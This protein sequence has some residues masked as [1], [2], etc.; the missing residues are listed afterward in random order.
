[1]A[2]SDGPVTKSLPSSVAAYTFFM[3]K[4][5]FD[6]TFR[7]PLLVSVSSLLVSD[8]STPCGLWNGPCFSLSSTSF[9]SVNRKSYIVHR[10]RK[11]LNPI[12]AEKTDCSLRETAVV[13]SPPHKWSDTGTPFDDQWHELQWQQ[14]RWRTDLKGKNVAKIWSQH[15]T[16]L[17]NFFLNTIITLIKRPLQ[18]FPAPTLIV[19][20]LRDIVLGPP[21]N[22]TRLLLATMWRPLNCPS[23]STPVDASSIRELFRHRLLKKQEMSNWYEQIPAM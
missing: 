6:R 14:D 8:V 21:A 17:V 13:F 15:G 18:Q 5:F 19:D 22:G 10:T 3:L 12:D 7:R 23:V 9:I 20:S 2:A 11:L 1:M 16:I 4:V